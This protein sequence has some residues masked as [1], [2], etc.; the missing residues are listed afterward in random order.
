ML[1]KIEQGYRLSRPEP[2]DNDDNSC[3]TFYFQLPSRDPKE[4]VLV[5]LLAEAVEQAFYNSLRTQQQLGYI[6][7]SGVR[8]REG[9]CSLAMSV[10]SAI[11]GGDELAQRIEAFVDAFTAE[12]G[13]LGQI[14]Q[15]DFVS[16]QQG[17]I[18]RKLEPDQ[19][20]TA[21][22]ARFWVR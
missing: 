18:V 11:L 19:R 16:Y 6:V 2:N 10:Q 1:S 14:S 17:L 4:Y 12:K 15:D 21:Q 9:I 7:Y 20:L 13:G 3:A 5:E 8:A 22:A